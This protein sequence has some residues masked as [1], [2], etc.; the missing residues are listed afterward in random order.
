MDQLGEAESF[1]REIAGAQFNSPAFIEAVFQ[2]L[3]S[4]KEQQTDT[5]SSEALSKAINMC[6]NISKEFKGE[7]KGE[8]EFVGSE[9]T[10]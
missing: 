2:A 7:C 1:L 8:S 3:L 4:L 6:A 10:L 5:A 9:P